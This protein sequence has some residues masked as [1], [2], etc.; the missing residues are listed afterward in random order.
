MRALDLLFLLVAGE[1]VVS[2]TEDVVLRSHKNSASGGNNADK[3][4]H[5]S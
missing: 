5:K 3:F 1:Y 4:N 2:M